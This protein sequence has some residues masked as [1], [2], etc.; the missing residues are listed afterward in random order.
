MGTLF[1]R[2]IASLGQF[3]IKKRQCDNINSYS[4]VRQQLR[5][6]VRLSHDV[7]K[8]FCCLLVGWAGLV[9]KVPH[10]TCR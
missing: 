10:L 1:S 8:V 7:E 9:P 2:M 6:G 4:I 3:G 5:A